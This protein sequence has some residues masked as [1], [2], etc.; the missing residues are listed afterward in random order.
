MHFT[1]SSRNIETEKREQRKLSEG[2]PTKNPRQSLDRRKSEPV[3]A[4]PNQNAKDS[5]SQEN[6]PEKINQLFD[7]FGLEE[8]DFRDPVVLREIR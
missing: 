1:E 4:I 8:A 3:Q 5:S 6:I 2:L 7:S